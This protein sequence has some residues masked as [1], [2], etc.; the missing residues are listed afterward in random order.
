MDDSYGQVSNETNIIRI[1]S[2][3]TKKEPEKS[4]SFA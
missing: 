3:E 2:V 1:H 4:G